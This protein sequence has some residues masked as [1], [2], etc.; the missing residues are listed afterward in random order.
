M[1]T[2][3]ISANLFVQ[4]PEITDALD[5]GTANAAY[6]PTS[7]VVTDTATGEKSAVQIRSLSFDD[8]R[9]YIQDCFSDYKAEYN[10]QVKYDT[11]SEFPGGVKNA[12]SGK[13]H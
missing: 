4:D 12:F 5:A 3:N 2:R 6:D 7:F 8:Y 13:F 1:T 11:V 10:I 9:K